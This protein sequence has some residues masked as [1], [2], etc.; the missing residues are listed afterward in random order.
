MLQR[1]MLLRAGERIEARDLSIDAAPA[2]T[3]PVRSLV[4]ATPL[5]RGQA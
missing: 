1:A 4:E 3:V 5:R 2:I